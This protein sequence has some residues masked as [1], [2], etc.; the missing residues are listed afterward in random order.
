MLLLSSIVIVVGVKNNVPEVVDTVFITVPEATVVLVNELKTLPLPAPAAT[1][2]MSPLA[3][4]NIVAT[5]RLSPN[6]NGSA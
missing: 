5:T 1:S 2:P 6:E 3:P 4:D